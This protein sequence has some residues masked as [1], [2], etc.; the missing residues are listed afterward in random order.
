MEEVPG[1]AQGLG[2]KLLSCFRP[3]KMST[4]SGTEHGTLTK[5]LRPS[6]SPGNATGSVPSSLTSCLSAMPWLFPPHKRQVSAETSP[7]WV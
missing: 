7:P 4:E 6:S 5:T 3:W 1:Q 2:T